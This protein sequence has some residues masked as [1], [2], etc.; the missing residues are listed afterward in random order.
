MRRYRGFTL[1]EVLI[2]LAVLGVVAAM[3]IPSLM[4]STNDKELSVARQKAYATVSAFRQRLVAENELPVVDQTGF[5]YASIMVGLFSKYLS[6]S[7]VCNNSLSCWH[8]AN[9]WYKYNGTALNLA[10]N[11]GVITADGMLIANIGKHNGSC[12]A[13][14]SISSNSCY[15]FVVD[16][17]GFKKPNTWGKDII[18]FQLFGNQILPAGATGTF[19]ANS[20]FCDNTDVSNNSY[21]SN[22]GCSAK[23]ILDQPIP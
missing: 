4:N 21:W 10:D 7:K 2:T 19:A 6:T 8:S 16:V 15:H 12:A 17:N 3:S 18:D 1:A 9:A 5:D 14:P 11:Y 23:A 20:A 22:V 13:N